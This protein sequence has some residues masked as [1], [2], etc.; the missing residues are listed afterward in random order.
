MKKYWII[1]N[2]QPIG[3]FS[4]EELKVRRDFNSELPVWCNELPDWSTVGQV[5]ELACLIEVETEEVHQ[6]ETTVIDEQQPAPNDARQPN[7]YV[8]QPYIDIIVNAPEQI[9]GINRPKS[10]MGWNIAALLCCC[11]PAAVVGLIFSSQV[12]RHWMRGDAA[13]AV[14]SSEYAQWAFIISFTLG[15]V[16]WPFQLLML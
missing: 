4:A 14:R 16:S 5:P 6:P 11:L 7:N 8:H 3:P 2:G 15:L 1:E 10:Y 12:N 9:N 13:A